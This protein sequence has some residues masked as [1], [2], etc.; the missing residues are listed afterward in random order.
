MGTKDPNNIKMKRNTA[1]QRI[2][3]GDVNIVE[4]SKEIK[5]PERQPD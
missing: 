1:N 2:C 5:R 4:P 3:D